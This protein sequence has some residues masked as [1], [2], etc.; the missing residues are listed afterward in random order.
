MHFIK[1]LATHQAL[2]NTPLC[3]FIHNYRLPFGEIYENYPLSIFTKCSHLRS[4]NFVVIFYNYTKGSFPNW[5]D[6]LAY[7]QERWYVCVVLR[8]YFTSCRWLWQI[9]QVIN[10][11]VKISMLDSDG[12]IVLFVCVSVYLVHIMVDYS[13]VHSIIKYPKL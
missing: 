1:P 5:L 6:R 3:Q 12:Q 10:L 7:R 9:L 4:F 13:Q 8:I 2:M 11:W